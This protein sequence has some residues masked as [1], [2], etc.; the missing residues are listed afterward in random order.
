M[1]FKMLV[2]TPKLDISDITKKG[3]KDQNQKSEYS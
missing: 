1:V 3:F 2:L